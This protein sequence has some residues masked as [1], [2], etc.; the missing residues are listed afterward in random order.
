MRRILIYLAL[1]L[2]LF[3]SQASD[4]LKE[5]AKVYREE[6]YKLQSHGDLMGAL[7]FYQKAIN[8]NPQ[9]VEVCNDIGVIYEGLGDKASALAMYKRALEID[10]NCLSAYTNLALLYENLG[11]K[12]NAG[13]NW[14]RR[15]ELGR[16]G[17]YWWE[18]SRDHLLKLGTYPKVRKEV[19]ERAAAKMSQ[20][21]VY[22]HEQ[23]RLK[24]IDEAKLHFEIGLGFMD[25]GD[26][27]SALGELE[28][29][30]A[31]KISDAD[32]SKKIEDIYQV[33][34]KVYTKQ[35]ALNSTKEAAALIKNDEFL[36]AGDKL[37]S[38]L[39]TTLHISKDK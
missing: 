16:E 12:D 21:L 30:R 7:S 2:P 5:Q 24:L 35:Q 22:K 32:L 31:I 26:Y 11:D 23:E 39:S 33:A 19:L 37:Q 34:V 15:Y 6:G 28:T 38:A 3:S 9:N 13:L 29:A 17:E 4:A 27:G 20:E 25:K 1:L 14:Q 36:S 10:P 8:L 18:V